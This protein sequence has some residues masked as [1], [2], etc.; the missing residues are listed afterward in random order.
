MENKN[1]KTQNLKFMKKFGMKIF[2]FDIML[3]LLYSFALAFDLF[4]YFKIEFIK[5]YYFNCISALLFFSFLMMYVSSFIENKFRYKKYTQIE[6]QDKNLEQKEIILNKIKED[7]IQDVDTE[8]LEHQLEY[9]S[10]IPE[11][12]KKTHQTRLFIRFSMVFYLIIAFIY[13]LFYDTFKEIGIDNSFLSLFNSP[14]IWKGLYIYSISFIFI[15]MTFLIALMVGNIT[16]EITRTYIFGFHIHE[17]ILG[18]LVVLI[19]VPLI[20]N[21]NNFTSFSFLIGGAF[22]VSGIFL[23]GRDWRDVAKGDLIVHYS[24]EKDYEKYLNLMKNKSKILE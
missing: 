15:T 24:K 22:L 10:P 16:E 21:S 6:H 17:S 19:G 13:E 11:P 2:L 18:V 8:F 4:N 9:M 20:I 12:S 7:G 23:I 1:K 3:F 14:I 5:S